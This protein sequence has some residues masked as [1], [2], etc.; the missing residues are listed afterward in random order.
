MDMLREDNY[1]SWEFSARMQL[2]RKG[3]LDHIDMVKTPGEDDSNAADW[4]VNDMKAFAIVSTMIRPN[5]QSMFR[6]AFGATQAWDILNNFF[7]R[8]SL[9]NRIQKKREL[10]DFK[11]R[12]GGSFRDHFLRF[13]EL[14]M[15]MQAIGAS[16]DLNEQLVVLLGSMSEDFD[17]IMK[18]MENVPGMA[19]FQ[20]KERLLRESESISA[21][22]KHGMRFK[23]QYKRQS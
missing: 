9:H 21:K 12:K 7:L 15:S 6:S 1:S 13:E 4:K 17:Q 3:L 16:I 5:L 10:H 18:I 20:A 14:C 19:M 11:M 8:R 22:K 2:M 23:A